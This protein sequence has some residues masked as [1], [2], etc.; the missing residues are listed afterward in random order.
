MARSAT[1]H[2][3]HHAA[4][5]HRR[6]ARQRS[7]VLFKYWGV[8]P[9]FTSMFHNFS[10]VFPLMFLIFPHFRTYFSTPFPPHG[11]LPHLP[12][13]HFPETTKI[14]Q[15]FCGDATGL[16]F[17]GGGDVIFSVLTPGTKLRPHCGPS[18]ARLTCHLGIR[19]RE[20]RAREGKEEYVI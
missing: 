17:C 7:F 2:E 12:Q 10:T 5:I 18:N 13:E 6:S 9:V 16:A 8:V 3:L 1:L 11:Q 4:G 20:P 15:T 19:V 14:L